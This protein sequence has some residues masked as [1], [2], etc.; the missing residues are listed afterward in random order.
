MGPAR[1]SE[2]DKRSSS[3]SSLMRGNRRKS[4]ALKLSIHSRTF[5]ELGAGS[6]RGSIFALAASGIGTGILSLPYVF[7][8]CGWGLGL[9]LF[10]TSA[11][12]TEISLRM[13]TH[14]AIKHNMPNYNKIAMMA[15][16]QKLSTFL[17]G[18]ILLYTFGKGIG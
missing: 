18:M 13:L 8:L 5:S 17:T 2:H 12:A 10:M 6:L 9:I 7:G 14:L 4:I 11:I 16:G 15:G 1:V 3:S